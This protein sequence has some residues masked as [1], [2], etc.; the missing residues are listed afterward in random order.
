MTRLRGRRL[1]A[2]AAAVAAALVVGHAITTRVAVGTEDP[3]VRAV[4]V[5]ETAHLV[6]ADVTVTDVR[7]A[8]RLLGS[9]STDLPLEGS[10]VF[11]VALLELTATREPVRLET[12]TLV[13]DQD[14]LYRTSVKS[15]CTTLPPTSPTAV[16]TYV[17]AC[18]DVPADRLAGLR[19]QAARGDVGDNSSRRDDVAEVDLGISGDDAEDWAATQDG[20]L[21]RDQSFVPFDLEPFDPADL[22]DLQGT[23]S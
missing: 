21:V 19:L 17:M 3:F 7:P 10:E 2:S 1:V 16:T 14:R 23:T 6:Y 9:L 22:A 11:V 4:E 15:G 13:D 8:R 18:F 20:Y 5:G 12:L